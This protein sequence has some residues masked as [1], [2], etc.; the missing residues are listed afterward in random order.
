MPSFR[1][2]VAFVSLC[3]VAVFTLPD[4][5]RSQSNTTPKKLTL[6]LESRE[7]FQA[8]AST[9]Y[10]VQGQRII[11]LDR[12]SWQQRWVFTSSQA[13]IPKL[14]LDGDRVLAL[15][16]GGTLAAISAESGRKLWSTQ[17]LTNAQKRRGYFGRGLYTQ[18]FPSFF[19]FKH[20]LMATQGGEYTLLEKDG[21]RI[22][23][24]RDPP[25]LNG[26]SY[27][28][29]AFETDKYYVLE[30]LAFALPSLPGPTSFLS[31][32][33]IFTNDHRL[34][35]RTEQYFSDAQYFMASDIYQLSDRFLSSQNGLSTGIDLIEGLEAD[36]AS[37][38]YAFTLYKFN[39]LENQQVPLTRETTGFA[40]LTSHY[41]NREWCGKRWCEYTETPR[42][43]E[44]L[45]VFDGRLYF[46]TDMPGKRFAFF[47]LDELQRHA[48]DPL[49][50]NQTNTRYVQNIQYTDE[51][52]TGWLTT[53]PPGVTETDIFAVG[54]TGH[55]AAVSSSGALR[56]V[57][58]ERVTEVSQ[59]SLMKNFIPAR[60]LTLGAN[61]VIV[62]GDS[63]I[64]VYREAAN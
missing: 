13:W 32:I 38:H 5:A 44:P 10:Y 47:E 56:I 57:D 52:P 1:A 2:L 48:A 11:A 37:T 30:R 53:P 20:H 34:D 29:K 62:R 3:F 17:A 15:T 23:T 12:K 46:M 43:Y 21:R 39:Y 58:G 22:K 60:D 41:R 36:D 49:I 51:R 64:A 45:G 18:V 31:L 7:A 61:D 4:H 24:V 33:Q 55:Y 9:L 50:A 19:V 28:R 54:D 63:L 25:G 59:T 40:S 42:D 8:S 27:Y 26:I 6:Q 16:W 35:R 14:E